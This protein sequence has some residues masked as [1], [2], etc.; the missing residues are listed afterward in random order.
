MLDQGS[1]DRWLGAVRWG[2]ASDLPIAVQFSSDGPLLSVAKAG[3]ESS[4]LRLGHNSRVSA[5]VAAPRSFYHPVARGERGRI[6]SAPGFNVVRKLSEQVRQDR[7][8][9]LHVV[10][11]VVRRF[12]DATQPREA[13]NAVHEFPQSR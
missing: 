1:A 4:S 2:S 6:A 11:F 3:A 5:S 9:Q 10:P 7:S 8:Q 13:L 12:G